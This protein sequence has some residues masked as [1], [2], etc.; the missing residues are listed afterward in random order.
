MKNGFLLPKI[1]DNFKLEKK[2][3]K[4]HPNLKNKNAFMIYQSIYS[5]INKSYYLA[6]YQEVSEIIMHSNDPEEEFY[7]DYYILKKFKDKKSLYSAI[8]KDKKEKQKDYKRSKFSGLNNQ[9]L[10]DAFSYKK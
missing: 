7:S 2:F 3:E 1:N 8:K 5:K 4:F 10:L 9:S 6:I